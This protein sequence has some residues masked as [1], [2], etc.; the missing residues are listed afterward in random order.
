MATLAAVNQV[1]ESIVALLRA[2]RDLLAADGQLAPVPAALAITHASLGQLATTQ[3]PTAGLT[4]TLYRV[5]MSDHP[6]P[7]VQARRPASGASI[8]VELH[9]LLTAWPA[10]TADEQAII[11]WAMLEL[12]AHP[13][14]DRALLQGANV[15][16][17]DETVQIV[18]DTIPNDELFRI[19]DAIQ[20]KYRLSTTFRARV[21]RIG[22]G[23]PETW[24]PVVA[25]RFG[26][27][28]T[29]PLTQGAG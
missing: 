23:P 13:V 18:P 11:A 27:A 24:P 1:G 10:A 5:S 22:Y 9:Y 28:D 29:D 2:R 14:L 6:T 12:A 20:H 21:V 19:W 16:E 15:W 25:T 7:R 17:R 26:L 8:A 3:E 4:V